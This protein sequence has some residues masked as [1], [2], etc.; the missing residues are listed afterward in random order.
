M[1]GGGPRG[2]EKIG[3][4]LFLLALYDVFLLLLIQNLVLNFKFRIAKASCFGGVEM[5]IEKA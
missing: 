5:E 1:A 3:K 4:T 2:V